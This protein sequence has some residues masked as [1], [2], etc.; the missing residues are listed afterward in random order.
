MKPPQSL[1]DSIK[2][3]RDIRRRSSAE[4]RSLAAEVRRRIVE[5]ISQNGGH[6]ASNLGT[7]E[8]TIALH[9][10]F[11]S[12]RDKILWDVGRQCYTHKLLTGR[13][14]QFHTI[15]R[16]NGISGFPKRS[17][18][19]H[20]ILNTGHASTALSAALGF[21]LPDESFREYKKGP[22]AWFYTE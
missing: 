12:P 21:Q 7:V 2:E 22:K 9:R 11:E 5:V 4:L 1:L 16:Q 3:P 20:D 6:L 18:N 19:C 17:E 8:L 14:G 10:V 13:N 15:R